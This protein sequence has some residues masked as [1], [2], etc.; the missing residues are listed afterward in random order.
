MG[1]YP[2]DTGQFHSVSA[3]RGSLSPNLILPRTVVLDKH[4]S[5]VVRWATDKKRW[6]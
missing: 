6:T 1:I 3:G 4:N 5:V 2:L